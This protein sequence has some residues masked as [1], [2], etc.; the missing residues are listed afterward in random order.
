MDEYY[1]YLGQDSHRQGCHFHPYDEQG[2]LLYKIPQRAEYQKE[3]TRQCH[4]DGYQ[5]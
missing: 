3:N 1:A 2:H 4:Q 5:D